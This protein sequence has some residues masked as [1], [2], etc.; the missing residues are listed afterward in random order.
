MSVGQGSYSDACG[1][2]LRV[3]FRRV[4]LC[5]FVTIFDYGVFHGINAISYLK[6]IV[7]VEFQGLI[8][9][10]VGMIG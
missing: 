2:R 3:R 6:A 5:V 9:N 1:N 8:D 4:L 10:R 7:I